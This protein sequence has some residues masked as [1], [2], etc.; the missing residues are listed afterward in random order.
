VST[1]PQDLQNLIA[2][3][4]EQQRRLVL[5]H[6]DNDDSWALGCLIVEIARERD[7]PIVVDI[8]R[9]GHQLFHASLAGTTPDNDAW[10]ARKVNVV[11]R[12]G[13]SSFLVGLRARAAGT[14]LPEQSGLADQDFA[15]HG[16]SFPVIISGV[17]P[18]GTV[19]VSGLTQEADH[20]LVVEALEQ[21]CESQTRP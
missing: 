1:T 4:T 12:F 15:A 13:E 16:G 10:V 19:T 21:V 6:F 17:G 3:I 2:E 20:A 7:L 11:D 14:T 18:V 8:R 5:K 9:H